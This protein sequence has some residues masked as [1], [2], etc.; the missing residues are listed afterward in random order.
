MA[1]DVDEGRDRPDEP[2]TSK[3]PPD[4]EAGQGGTGGGAA[5]A[6]GIGVAVAIADLLGRPLTPPGT[7]ADHGAAVPSAESPGGSAPISTGP[8]VTPD[9]GRGGG[10]A[11][12]SGPSSSSGG[13]SGLGRVLGLG[14]VAG[15][16]GT[17]AAGLLGGHPGHGRPGVGGP[18]GG[19]PGSGHAGG[20]HS[21]GHAVPLD[22]GTPG[23]VTG[24]NSPGDQGYTPASPQGPLSG[25][26]VTD[27]GHGGTSGGVTAGPDPT[28]GGGSQPTAGHHGTPATTAQQPYTVS[29]PGTGHHG[30]PDTTIGQPYSTQQ[31]GVP[32]HPGAY[33]GSVPAGYD[34]TGQP[35]AHPGAT[36]TTQPGGTDVTGLPPGTHQTTGTGAT[37]Q[38]LTTHGQNQNQGQNQGQP[39]YDVA[40]MTDEQKFVYAPWALTDAQKNQV[41]ENVLAQQNAAPPAGTDKYLPD[42]GPGFFGQDTYTVTDPSTKQKKTMNT[43]SAAATAFAIAGQLTADIQEQETLAGRLE[44]VAEKIWNKWV[45]KIMNINVDSVFAGN[46]DLA[47]FKSEFMSMWDGHRTATQ[48]VIDG[49]YDEGDAL[50]KVASAYFAT[51]QTNLGQFN[52]TAKD[53]R[54]GADQKEYVDGV[55]KYAYYKTKMKNLNDQ[56]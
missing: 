23:A 51:E 37:P 33:T 25:A 19:H 16:G 44:A 48:H 8:Q 56:P 28:S 40:N 17:A 4:D 1:H 54:G 22:P 7:S 39:Q 13:V 24:V 27:A 38:P 52:L 26:P 14:A 46:P 20:G 18:G 53:P 9:S 11:G 10:P 2:V 32:G 42:L 15:M 49:M 3:T 34:T 45:E 5:T 47:D 41:I 6:A 12:A 50:K 21:G 43:L 31:G 55:D 30:T 35:T 29:P 36:P